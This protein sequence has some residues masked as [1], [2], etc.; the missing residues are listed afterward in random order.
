MLDKI[1][2]M[3][4][5]H[6]VTALIGIATHAQAGQLQEIS[7][8]AGYRQDAASLGI[9]STLS[10][11]DFFGFGKMRIRQAHLWEVG[12][13]A[14]YLFNDAWSIG[15]SLKYGFVT[16]GQVRDSGIADINANPMNGGIGEIYGQC[17]DCPCTPDVC[18]CHC[19]GLLPHRLVPVQANLKGNTWDADVG[20]SYIF[21]M[22][23]TFFITPEIGWAFNYQR[24]RY[25]NSS[26]GPVS[27][28]LSYEPCP[29]REGIATWGYTPYNDQDSTY[30]VWRLNDQ[31]GHAMLLNQ[32][33]NIWFA[34]QGDPDDPT[35]WTF[36]NSTPTC[37]AAGNCLDGTTYTARW[38]GGY[39]GIS[40][41]R[42]FGDDWAVGLNYRFF[43]QRYHGRFTTFG[44]NSRSACDCNQCPSFI[45]MDQR[46]LQG[47]PA[48]NPLD[49]TL[50][51]F[52]ASQM[53]FGSWGYGQE[54][55]LHSDWRCND[56]VV[57]IGAAYTYR[58]SPNCYDVDPC[59][60]C[61]TIINA[62][63][64]LDQ[65]PETY[66]WSNARKTSARWSSFNILVNAGYLF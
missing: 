64:S 13:N 59:N 50:Q 53:D 20:L 42:T 48:D 57:G 32:S 54:I 61:T 17:C 28:Y 3:R 10:N 52:A 36:T 65:F 43:L 27:A 22:K 19:E 37:T 1:V 12:A 9:C 8:Q 58:V 21:N 51:G 46:Y 38:N 7:L 33:A 29:V 35:K 25:R 60:S 2:C 40:F 49:A 56:W 45:V 16:G 31:P 18:A 41:D 15:A 39:L 47:D 24:Y 62:G 55:A 11:P 4:R 30:P 14:S 5:A 66:T 26:W 23:D 34:E 6:L 44:G 63:M